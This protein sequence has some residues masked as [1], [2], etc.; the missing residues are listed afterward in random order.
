MYLLNKMETQ[1]IINKTE[2]ASS[3]ECGRA[4]NRHKIYYENAA[5]LKK[6]LDELKELG[7]YSSELLQ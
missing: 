2:R 5:D 3:Y 7:L 1:T 6:Q 4:G